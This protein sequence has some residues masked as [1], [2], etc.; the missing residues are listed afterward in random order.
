[1][2][3]RCHTSLTSCKC[4]SA[5]AS[6]PWH[7]SK[8]VSFVGIKI[9]LFLSQQS[10]FK[11]PPFHNLLPD[12]SFKIF[13]LMESTSPWL[14]ELNTISG[15]PPSLSMKL[16]KLN[17]HYRLLESITS[18]SSV[19]YTLLLA[20][21]QPLFCSFTMWSSVEK[22]NSVNK[23][24]PWSQDEKVP[25]IVLCRAAK[26]SRFGVT[27]LGEMEAEPAWALEKLGSFC[28]QLYLAFSWTEVL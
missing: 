8:H 15:L 25:Q 26:K 3:T 7:L 17:L 13:A 28:V 5:S 21:L 11:I 9:G 2:W 12:P 20:V 19:Y 16:T 27:K 23:F 10:G 24:L 14:A 22:I 4:I 1:M 18:F 6:L